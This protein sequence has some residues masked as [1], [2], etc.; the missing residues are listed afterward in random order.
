MIEWLT[1]LYTPCWCYSASVKDCQDV[2]RTQGPRHRIDVE[3][4]WHDGLPVCHV[5]AVSMKSQWIRQECTQRTSPCAP[6]NIDIILFLGDG[7]STMFESINQNCPAV[8]INIDQVPREAHGFPNPKGKVLLQQRMWLVSWNV[9]R[10]SMS[11]HRPIEWVISGKW[12][13]TVYKNPIQLHN[14][15]K[16]CYTTP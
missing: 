13:H 6:W 14:Q 5:G 4:P 15:S 7:T 2:P 16:L 10:N 3:E 11:F 9:L 8:W 1:I 12:Y